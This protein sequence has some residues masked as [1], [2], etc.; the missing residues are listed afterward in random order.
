MVARILLH[1]DHLML[2]DAVAHHVQPFRIVDHLLGDQ[3]LA[4]DQ[5]AELAEDLLHL[6]AQLGGMHEED[7]HLL[8]IAE[9]GAAMHERIIGADRQALRL[10]RNVGLVEIA[11]KHRGEADDVADAG[12]MVVPGRA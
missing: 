7:A 9:G 11:Q 2:L 10:R 1:V 12:A 8:V 4:V 6:L 3:Q 5:A